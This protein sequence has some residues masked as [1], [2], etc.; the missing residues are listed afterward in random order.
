MKNLVVGAGL[1]GAVIAERLAKQLNENV[2]VI[3]KKSFVGGSLYDYVDT[4]SGITIQKY[5]A[6]V[7]HTDEKF[8]WDYL[9]NFTDWH[10]FYFEPKVLIQGQEATLPVNL[11]TLYNVFPEQFAKMLEDKLLTKFGYNSRVLI[12]ELAK[13]F[14]D[15]LKFLANYFYENIFKPFTMKQLGLSASDIPKC[16]DSPF[17]IYVSIDD[18]YYQDKYQ[19]MP[20]DGWTRMIENILNDKKI[21]IKLNTDFTDIN[22]Q[23]FDRIFYTGSI[24]EYFDYKYGELSYR[25]LHIDLKEEDVEQYQS[26]P[27]CNV[28]FDFDFTR[29]IEY[30]LFGNKTS[31]KTILGFEYS[32]NFVLGK[33]ERSY[34]IRTQESQAIYEKYA[35]EV[36]I[37][38]NVYFAGTF[39]DFK[40]YEA[41]GKINR[42]FELINKIMMPN[43]DYKD[44]QE[45]SIEI[46]EAEETELSQ[47]E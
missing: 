36:K 18:R 46:V 31:P 33:N 26:A 39:G 38:D 37:L 7:F 34:P 10:Y 9:S 41:D 27:V 28:P 6:N 21:K 3:D 29:I 43:N 44:F 40:Y 15:D 45:N 17:P 35:D 13:N 8:I 14:D 25:S 19:A 32:E 12:S 11:N 5:G 22:P 47:D 16:E 2:L 24:D 23:K 4:K 1:T 42:A 30:K 20:K